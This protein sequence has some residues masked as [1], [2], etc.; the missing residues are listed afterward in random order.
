MKELQNTL[1]YILQEQDVSEQDFKEAKKAALKEITDDQK[2]I[3]YG[4][5]LT[6][7]S[8]KEILEDAPDDAIICTERVEDEYFEKHNWKTENVFDG[9]FNHEFI[10]SHA[11]VCDTKLKRIYIFNHF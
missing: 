3:D 8:L 2:G 4:M 9:I 1:K 7:K 5:Y 10:K 11:A 6:V